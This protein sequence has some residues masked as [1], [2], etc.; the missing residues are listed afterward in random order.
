M[1]IISFYREKIGC[2]VLIVILTIITT[3]PLFSYDQGFSLEAGLGMTL[4]NFSDPV[5][6]AETDAGSMKF[7]LTYKP[8]FMFGAYGGYSFGN[9]ELGGEICFISGSG[10]SSNMIVAGVVQLDTAGTYDFSMYRIAPVFRYYF[11]VEDPTIKPFAGLAVGYANSTVNID[12]PAIKFTQGYV[13]VA[14]LGGAKYFFDEQVYLGGSLRIDLYTTI[15]K[16]DIPGVPGID[17]I[18]NVSTDGWAPLSL[19]IFVGYSL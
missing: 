19:N 12:D 13:D 3:S 9:Y 17:S 16:D 1:N 7:D 4:F 11:A 6:K 10:S 2:F 14:L 18:R 5:L 8:G 15:V